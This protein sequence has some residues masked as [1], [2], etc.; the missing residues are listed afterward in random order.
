MRPNVAQHR[1]DFVD[2]S[3]LA[4]LDLEKLGDSVMAQTLRELREPE[5]D[6]EDVFARFDNSTAPQR[7]GEWS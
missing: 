4:S 6:A 2:L 5:R 1:H 3:P 7:D